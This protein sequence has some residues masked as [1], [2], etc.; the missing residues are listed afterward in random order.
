MI[1]CSYG[2]CINDVDRVPCKIVGQTSYFAFDKVHLREIRFAGNLNT[3][4]MQHTQCNRDVNTVRSPD[5]SL[6]WEGSLGQSELEVPEAPNK[7]ARKEELA[8]LSLS[9]TSDSEASTSRG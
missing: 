6:R 5:C 9:P 1:E 7:L 2:P 3:T 8:D 4:T